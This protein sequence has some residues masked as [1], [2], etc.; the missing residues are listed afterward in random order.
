MSNLTSASGE[1][2]ATTSYPQQYFSPSQTQAHDETPAKKRRNPPGKPD[3]EAEVI[4][5]SP[6]TLMA[7]NRFICK[8][9]NK[10]FQRDQNLQLHKRG[11]NLPW[12]LKKHGEKKWKCDKCS[13]K[14]AVQSDWKAHSK[15]CGTREYRCDC[16]TLFTRR[17]SF[18][19]HRAFCDALAEESSR[20]VIH[21]PSSHN[22]INN[23]TQEIQ[24]PRLN[25][26]N[27]VQSLI[28]AGDLDAASAVARHSVISSTRPTVFTCN[29]IIAAMYHAKRYTEAI[30][31]F[32]FF[33]NQ[34]NLVPNIV[35]Y[36]NLINTHCDEGRVDVALG[37]YRHIIDQ[38]PFNTP[39]E[40][41]L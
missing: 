6:K 34:S 3:L 9:C 41:H 8:I 37:I 25:L 30:A 5:L 14:Y 1:A 26:H 27:R 35:S 15:T 22:M 24:G 31:L 33:F 19:T 7:T 40:L 18:I 29:A 11:H 2:S 36:N 4:A 16:G 17:D 38:A 21:Q 39:P 13:K 12:K 20:S 28:R 32:H 23:Q 10:G